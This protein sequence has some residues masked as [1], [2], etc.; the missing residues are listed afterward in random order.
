MTSSYQA[1]I[2]GG[3]PFP[4]MMMKLTNNSNEDIT[5]SYNGITAHEYIP[6]MTQAIFD[7]QSNA[8]GGNNEAKVAAA[9]NIY[10]KGTSGTGNFYVSGWYQQPRDLN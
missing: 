2:T 4:L 8:G 9:T 7:F 10:V 6:A 3:L 1:V 5:I